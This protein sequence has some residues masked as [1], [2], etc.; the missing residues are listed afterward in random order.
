MG[1]ISEVSAL[2]DRISREIKEGNVPLP[3]MPDIVT[4][5]FE[6]TS[7]PNSSARDMAKLVMS[8]HT[9]TARIMEVSNSAYF[10]CG[11]KITSL[12]HAVARLGFRTISNLV[13]VVVMESQFLGNGRYRAMEEKLWQ[14]SLLTAFIAKHVAEEIRMDGEEAYLVGLIH[15]IGKSILLSMV[16]NALKRTKG[17]T[18]PP[19]RAVTKFLDRFHTYVGFLAAGEWNM[20]ERICEAICFHH[21]FRLSKRHSDLTALTQLGNELA[22]LAHDEDKDE[23]WSSPA[24]DRLRISKE[25]LASIRK[26]LGDIRNTAME[27]MG[28]AFGP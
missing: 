22:H 4:R 16:D 8:D 28:S 5:V 9:L 27:V 26:D 6:V 11:E 25:S 23:S 10:S 18:P 12:H 19:E 21:D 20:S 13:M 2:I 17:R 7:N 15:D 14:H 24:A 3:V 1:G